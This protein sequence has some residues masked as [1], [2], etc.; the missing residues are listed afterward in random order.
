MERTQQHRKTM[1]NIQNIC[2]Q[3]DFFLLFYIQSKEF[4]IALSE[5]NIHFV[6]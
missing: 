3:T 2:L 4:T 1:D 6:F 5:K